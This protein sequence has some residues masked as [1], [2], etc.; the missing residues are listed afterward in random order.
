MFNALQGVGQDYQD[1]ETPGGK[2]FYSNG[3]DRRFKGIVSRDFWF[4]FFM[5]HLPP[6]PWKLSFGLFIFFGKFVE[7]FASQGAP[8]VS[9]ILVANLPKVSMIP[10]A[11]LYRWCCWYWVAN[12]PKV[13]ITPVVIYTIYTLSYEYLRK[14]SKIFEKALTRYSGA[15]GRGTDSWKKTVESSSPNPLKIKFWSFHIFWKIRG[16]IRKSRCTTGI[17]DS[18]GKF[19][20]GINDTGGKFVSLVLLILGGKYAEGINNN[21]GNFPLVSM[22]LMASNGNNI[23]LLY[24]LVKMNKKKLSI[25]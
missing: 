4:S 2:N 5:N 1:Q 19:A 7:I 16:D 20:K 9:T 3:L 13:S 18:G 6:I 24:T 23:R 21:D 11:N 14:F 10:V 22:T 17:N 8:P 12:M 15:W 25:C